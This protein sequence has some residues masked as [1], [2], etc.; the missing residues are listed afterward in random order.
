MKPVVSDVGRCFYSLSGSCVGSEVESVLTVDYL[1]AF[2]VST[3]YF[4]KIQQFQQRTTLRYMYNRHSF[5]A[6][7]CSM[8][9][10][11]P[12][13][14]PKKSFVRIYLNDNR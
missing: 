4:S 6:S 5:M 2:E 1:S 12:R 9:N 14:H 10:R 3:K 13:K 7:L 11:C 8:Q